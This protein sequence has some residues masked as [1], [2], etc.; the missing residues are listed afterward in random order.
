MLDK[1][2]RGRKL[3]GASLMAAALALPL[4]CFVGI[5][6]EAQG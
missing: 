2:S 6:A 5:H 1:L 3:L 4:L